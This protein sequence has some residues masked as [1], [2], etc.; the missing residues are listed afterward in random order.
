[1]DQIKG[2]NKT[3]LLWLIKAGCLSQTCL[4]ALVAFN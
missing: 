1:M 4:Y 2:S 3:D